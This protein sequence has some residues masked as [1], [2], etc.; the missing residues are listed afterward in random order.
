[1]LDIPH[2]ALDNTYGK[3]ASYVSAWTAEYR[4]LRLASS[5]DEAL[6]ELDHMQREGDAA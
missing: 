5:L 1:L 2:V 4:A 6:A 3:V